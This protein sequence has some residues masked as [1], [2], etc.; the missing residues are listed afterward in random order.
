MKDAKSVEI[1]EPLVFNKKALKETS[2]DYRFA[3]SVAEF[4][5][6]L[7]DN[8]NKANATYDQVI[9]LAEGA[10]AKTQRA[11]EKSLSD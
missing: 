2:T 1:T 6:L 4:G 3:A 8:S 11:T 7:R 10:I 9:E 5:I